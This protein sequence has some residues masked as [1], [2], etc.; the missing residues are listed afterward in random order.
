MKRLLL[1]PLVLFGLACEPVESIEPEVEFYP[2]GHE[3]DNGRYDR[4]DEIRWEFRWPK[5]KGAEKYRIYVIGA[6][7]QF[8]VIDTTSP[9]NNYLHVSEGSYII[10]RHRFDWEWK[11]KGFVDGQWTEWLEPH[12]FD[13]E[14]A[15]T[16][17][18]SGG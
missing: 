6:N 13:V 9:D 1:I 15:D 4:Q 18:A 16:D 2:D 17:P 10:D 11:V 5:M 8:P 3:M 14:A 7:A 12:M